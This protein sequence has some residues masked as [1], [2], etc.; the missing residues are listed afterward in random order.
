MKGLVS[1]EEY[2]ISDAS[3]QR[4]TYLME[5]LQTKSP[6]VPQL[7]V[8]QMIRMRKKSILP[9]PIRVGS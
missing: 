9:A 4:G 2:F 8:C 7:A 5:G 3:A 6:S 1:C